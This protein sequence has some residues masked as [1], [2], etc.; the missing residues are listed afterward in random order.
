MLL[1]A[2]EAAEALAEAAAAASNNAEMADTILV[3][4]LACHLKICRKRMHCLR[5]ILVFLRCPR[6][7]RV[8]GGN[9][10]AASCD[11]CILMRTQQHCVSVLCRILSIAHP[12]N[13]NIP[14]QLLP[15]PATSSFPV[16][17]PWLFIYWDSI[18]NS[19]FSCF[20]SFHR[21]N[22]WH[23]PER[24]IELCRLRHRPRLLQSRGSDSLRAL[25]LA[26]L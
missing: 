3:F 12:P 23:Y 25:R 1:A 11:S 16:S 13:R 22:H 2:G 6:R 21:H 26:L 10:R 18:R 19:I 15:S 5:R 20:C 14:F 9:R 17:A 24:S 8:A 7:R 4:R